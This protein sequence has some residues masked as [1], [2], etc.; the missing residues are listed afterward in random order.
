MTF[1][2]GTL[3]TGIDAASEAF[4]P[5]GAECRYGAEIEPY[6]CGVLADRH[7]FGKPLRM[8]RPEDVDF[9]DGFDADD[10][11][12]FKA[13][14]KR[15]PAELSG[16][17][18]AF[19]KAWLTRAERRAAIR[20]I[21]KFPR[22]G[23]R[24]PNFGDLTQIDPEELPAVDL[25]VA[26]FPCQDFSI[27]GM[28]KSLAGARGN[29]TLFGVML[30]HE[31]RKRCRI[32]AVLLEQVPDILNTKDN[33]FGA[34]LG[35]LVGHDAPLVSPLPGGRWPNAGV[36]DGPLGQAV[37][38]VE[39]AQY[40]GVPQRRER[41]FV[42]ASFGDGPDP[43]PVL[44]ER[45]GLSRDP[46]SR[47]KAGEGVA[48]PLTA[49]SPGGSGYRLDADTA[50]NL[51]PTA[52]VAPTLRAKHNA[53]HRIDSDTY[54]AHVA[55]TLTANGKAAGSATQQ[56]AE[57]GLLVPVA[58]ENGGHFG[59]LRQTEVGA[60]L[61]AAGGDT[62]DGGETLIAHTLRGQGFDASEDGTGRGTPIVPV[63][64]SIMPQN[65]GKDYKAREV[66][67]AQPLMAAGPVGGNQGG[68]YVVQPVAFNWQGGGDQTTLGF[69]PDSETTGALH[70]GQT[71][72]IAFSCKDH[73]ADAGELSPT[74]RA[75]GHGAT[76]PNAGGQVAVAIPIQE[77]G[78]RTG[79]SSTSL[80][81]GDGLGADGDPM[82]T[83]GTDSR[84]AVAFSLRGREGGAMP[85]VEAGEVSPG[86]R[87]ADG[88]STRP[89]VA[90]QGRGSN[91]DLGQDVTGT[92]ASNADRASGGATCVA[93]D[94]AVRRITVV[95]AC[96]LQ[97]FSDFYTLIEWPTANR[98]GQELEE[99]IAYLIGHGFSPERAAVLAQTPDGPQYKAIG[100]S[101]CVPLV[102]KIGA[103]FARELA[104]YLAGKGAA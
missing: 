45:Q 50:E 103:A 91:I 70:V 39:D 67:V 90:F 65:S 94:M 44:L 22:W 34:L 32:R 10:A 60:P 97:G 27:A 74:L 53:S 83:V 72:A 62:G 9:P 12:L 104:L 86:L 79:S 98:K 14:A 58:F 48:R 92:L 4:L 13:L 23:D 37:W 38:R 100:N 30:I 18:G 25:L 49:G 43:V 5:L 33:A 16:A 36:A 8:P 29:L 40:S 2:F 19:V 46:P 15:R 51:I 66:D 76:H 89:F 64:Y 26:G 1:T 61:R 57:Q 80:K 101:K 28:R 24:L 3:C 102:R 55:G 81:A 7:G 31:L 68:D 17:Q 93:A 71:P 96:R 77:S 52:E 85:E 63:T 56:D 21:E 35:G 84:H 78:K 6:P 20:T 73:G 41:V 47:R 75:M 99:Q 69:D 87:A 95:E 59:A 11:A 88:G 82:F 42:V 54:V